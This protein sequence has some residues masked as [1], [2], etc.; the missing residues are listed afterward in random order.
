[1][2]RF[3]LRRAVAPEAAPTLA[4]P[5]SAAPPV[6]VAPTPEPVIAPSQAQDDMLDMRLRLHAKLIEEIDLSKRA[7]RGEE[8][9]GDL[10]RRYEDSRGKAWIINHKRR[11][12]EPGQ[13]AEIRFEAEYTMFAPPY[14]NAAP[15]FEGFGDFE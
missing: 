10:I 12:G 6:A 1:M 5:S 11:R 9:R 13:S 2:G 7:K 8:K 15:S 3:S 4:Q 14:T